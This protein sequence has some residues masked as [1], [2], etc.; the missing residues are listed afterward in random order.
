M[1][2]YIRKKLLLL[3]TVTGPLRSY[4]NYYFGEKEIKV[5]FKLIKTLNEDFY[6]F[7]I[8]ANYGIYTFMF[9]KN[10]KNI[11][12][13]EPISECIEYIQKG[14]KSKN[15]EYHNK[16]VSNK[17]GIGEIHIPIILNEKIFGKSSVNKLFSKYEKR[18]VSS[19]SID[20]FTKINNLD[21]SVLS[22]IKIDAEGHEL[23]IIKGAIE[24]LKKGRFLLLIEIEERHNQKFKEVFDILSSLNFKIYIEENGNFKFLNSKNIVY[25]KMK[26]N[27]NFFFK[28]F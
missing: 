15:I 22:I 23:D 12:V 28:N 16:I 25:E 26:T 5:L 11:F 13:F 21:S 4:Y 7:D 17:D 18:K 10:S 9:G 19:I 1:I 3:P 6:F 24:F 8:G 2:K 20:S 14:Y 27:N